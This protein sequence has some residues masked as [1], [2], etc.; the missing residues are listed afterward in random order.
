MCVKEIIQDCIK[1]QTF[2]ILQHE[3]IFHLLP[4][5]SVIKWHTFHSSEKSDFSGTSNVDIVCQS[6]PLCPYKCSYRPCHI[7]LLSI[8]QNTCEDI[9][10]AL[11][12][13]MTLKMHEMQHSQRWMAQNQHLF[14]TVQQPQ[15]VQCPN[16]RHVHKSPQLIK[17]MTQHI[18]VLIV[19]SKH[20]EMS[21]YINTHISH[22]YVLLECIM[23]NL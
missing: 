6:L 11:S 18:S 7:C 15:S 5:V 17:S 10:Y 21:L 19:N 1:S 16:A 9:K 23:G 2:N 3:F 22:L 13:Q 4:D 14:P 8:L 20:Q 12:S